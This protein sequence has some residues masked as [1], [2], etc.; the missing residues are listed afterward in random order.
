[1]QYFIKKE[2]IIYTYLNK[3]A[4]KKVITGRLLEIAA[5][6]DADV[7]FKATPTTS[8]LIVILHIEISILILK[9]I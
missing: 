7:D 8:K 2:L 4:R 5:P 3:T 9:K 6:K 1:M